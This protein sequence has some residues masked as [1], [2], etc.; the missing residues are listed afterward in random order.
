MD[1]KTSWTMDLHA[2]LRKMHETTIFNTQ[3]NHRSN[4]LLWVRVRDNH[5]SPN[6]LNTSKATNSRSGQWRIL[7]DPSKFRFKQWSLS[8]KNVDLQF[9]LLDLRF[10]LQSWMEGSTKLK[11]RKEMK[12]CCSWALK[13]AAL[14]C[15]KIRI[16]KSEPNPSIYRL[17]IP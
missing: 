11:W 14:R 12:K 2:D 17:E 10:D 6:H 15:F 13:I 8:L 5:H 1:I 7:L 16:S 4:I 3:T 9:W